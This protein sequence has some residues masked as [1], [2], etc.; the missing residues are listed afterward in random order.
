MKIETR[1]VYKCE[2]CRKLYQIKKWAVIHED[3][4]RK[5]PKNWRACHGCPFLEKIEADY[6]HDTYFGEDVMKVRVLHCSEKEV[7]IYPPIV[8]AKGNLLDFGDKPN[9]PMP[10]QCDIYDQWEREE[11]AKTQW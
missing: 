7:Y 11:N 8:E 6:W 10:M 5:N 4:C 2:F 3:G 9:E 1:E